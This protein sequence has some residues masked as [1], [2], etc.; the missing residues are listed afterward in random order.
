VEPEGTR[1]T[2]TV[3]TLLGRIGAEIFDAV[4][5]RDATLELRMRALLGE[6]LGRTPD[7][8]LHTVH[9]QPM[10]PPLLAMMYSKCG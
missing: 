2:L 1:V 7:E 9:G 10:L 6:V 5:G 8:P 3:L 4:D